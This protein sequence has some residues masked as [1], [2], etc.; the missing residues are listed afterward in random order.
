[1]SIQHGM[2][3]AGSRDFD[4]MRQ[5]PEQAIAN[6]ARTPVRLFFLR[7]QNG[8]FHLFRQLIGIPERPPRPIRQPFQT[9]LFVTFENLVAGLPPSVVTSNPANGGHP[10][11]GQ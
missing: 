5:A 7:R 11:T 4:C 9:A 8:G 6:F 3:G 10:K 1:M 2:N